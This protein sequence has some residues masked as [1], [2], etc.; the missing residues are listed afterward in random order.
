MPLQAQASMYPNAHSS[1]RSTA[2]SSA[3][4]SNIISVAAVPHPDATPMPPADRAPQH[5]PLQRS[6]SIWATMFGGPSVDARC[7]ST[8]INRI[9]EMGFSKD[10]AV[11]ALMVND[12]NLARAIDSLTSY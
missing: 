11:A 2:Q 6:E 5:Q 9:M 1:A 10:Q 8:D 4:S 7:K 3:Q 12:F